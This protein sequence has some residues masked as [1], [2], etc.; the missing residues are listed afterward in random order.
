MRSSSGT[1]VHKPVLSVKP[2][3]PVIVNQPISRS[4]SDACSLQSI[5][6]NSQAAW[7]PSKFDNCLAVCC[8]SLL[9]PVDLFWGE[10]SLTFLKIYSLQIHKKM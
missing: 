4:V 10:D 2:A 9:T 3:E 8:L 5:P 6:E 7:Q 1:T